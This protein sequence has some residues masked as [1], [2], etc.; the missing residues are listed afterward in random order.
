MDGEA[1]ALML[2]LLG[3]PSVALGWQAL[4]GRTILVPWRVGHAHLEAGRFAEAEARFRETLAMAER[5]FGPDHWRTALHLNALGQAILAQ[6]RIDEAGPVV[7]RALAIAKRCDPLPH[8]HV[9]IVFLGASI[10]FRARGDVDR[11]QALVDRARREGR[12]SSVVR[13][14]IERTLAAQATY[15]RDEA[16]AADAYG[17]VPA[18]MLKERDARQLA[19]LGLR[20]LRAGDARRAVECLRRAVLV[21]ERASCGEFVEAFY[22]GLLGEALLRDGRHDDALG[23]LE[24]TAMDYEAIAGR[25]HPALAPVL[26]LVAE[27]RARAGDDDGAR[28][29]CRRVMTLAL[30]AAQQVDPYRASASA[31]DPLEPERERARTLLARLGQS[32]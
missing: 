10:Y 22:R 26:V 20:L 32:T 27:L 16:K 9:A 15:A 19:Q 25:S 28:R 30:P 3:A 11:G 18:D 24:Q 7:E 12:G 23:V 6:K 2:F 5:R 17:R 1:I 4:R 14:A 29:A 8:D 31:A 21:V 13:A